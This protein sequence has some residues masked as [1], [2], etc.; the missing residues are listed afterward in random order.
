MG[1]REIRT[2]KGWSQEQLADISG[3]SARTI[4]RI[5]SGEKAGMESLKALAAALQITLSDLNGEAS[6]MEVEP[7]MLERE[8]DQDMSAVAGRRWKEFFIHL[9]AFMIVITWAQGMARFFDIETIWPNL[10]TGGWGVFLFIHLIDVLN[11]NEADE[12]KV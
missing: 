9:A 10:I 11:D 6:T 5:E 2:K 3:V 8:K 7:K 1:L 4:Q 12:K